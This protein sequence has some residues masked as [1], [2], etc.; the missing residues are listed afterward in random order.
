MTCI[1]FLLKIPLYK[2]FHTFS[3]NYT[4]FVHTF[5]K[6]LFHH[7]FHLLRCYKNIYDLHRFSIENSS[8][9]VISHLF[10]RFHTFFSHL[11]QN[12]FHHIKR[13]PKCYKNIYDLHRF[14]IENFS[15]LAIS[16]LFRRFHTFF[17][18]FFNFFVSI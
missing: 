12:F 13:L 17:H 14:S 2:R 6:I 7:I 5:F 15:I 1:G 16:H 8:I 18:T 3:S 4:P 9:L 10:W 11:F